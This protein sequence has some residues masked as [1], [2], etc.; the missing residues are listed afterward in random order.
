MTRPLLFLDV[1]GVLAHSGTIGRGRAS[2]EAW[3]TSFYHAAT[4][5][6][7]SARHFVRILIETNARFVLSSTWRKSGHQV[8]GLRRALVNAGLSS[9]AQHDAW[10][11]STPTGGPTRSDEIAAY[12]LREDPAHTHVLVIDDG[13]VPG[14]W[15]QLDPRPNWHTGGL[16]VEHADQAIALLLAPVERQ[17]TA[18]SPKDIP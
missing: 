1:D 6:P 15:L 17:D 14:P 4:V 2:G 18:S 3:N 12:L 7:E 11:G 16:R 10:I 5:D 9:R 13:W 8:A